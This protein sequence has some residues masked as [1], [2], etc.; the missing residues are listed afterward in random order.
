MRHGDGDGTDTHGVPFGAVTN[1]NCNT[2]FY[3]ISAKPLV[4]SLRPTA[5]A[6]T[7][8]PQSK[9][10]EP[11]PK[12]KPTPATAPAAPAK[13]TQTQ[14]QTVQE[15]APAAATSVKAE[16]PDLDWRKA[17]RS[18]QLK[19]EADIGCRFPPQADPSFDKR[20]ICYSNFTCLKR[21]RISSVKC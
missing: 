12:V 19:L 13:Q 3:C 11:A 8:A 18:N 2:N 6:P 1:V 15:K 7:A 17:M 20:F 4:S 10:Q 16:E 21:S 5:S 14:Q 9:S